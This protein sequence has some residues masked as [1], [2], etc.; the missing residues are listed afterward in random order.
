MVDE[1]TAAVVDRQRS[2]SAS[3]CSGHVARGSDPR[4]WGGVLKEFAKGKGDGSPPQIHSTPTLALIWSRT[5]SIY[6]AK[7]RASKV[8]MHGEQ[9][10]LSFRRV[11]SLQISRG[12]F[13]PQLLKSGLDQSD[14]VG[15]GR[16]QPPRHLHEAERVAIKSCA[17][18]QR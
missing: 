8:R 15:F 9:P 2:A 6:F 12:G 16:H 4:G 18:G 11:Q 17:F 1:L 3:A 10:A 5:V 14:D 7:T 13:A